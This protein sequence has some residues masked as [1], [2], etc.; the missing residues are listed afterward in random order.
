MLELVEVGEDRLVGEVIGLKGDQM[1]VQVYEETSGM[2]T[3]A[4]IYG[5]VCHFRSN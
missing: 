1:T 5:T 3:G 2:Q 4:P